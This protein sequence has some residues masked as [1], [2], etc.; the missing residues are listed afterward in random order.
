[1]KPLFAGLFDDAALFPPGD[2]PLAE[3]VPAHRGHRTAWY[4]GRSGTRPRVTV[5]WH[6]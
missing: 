1:M 3:A 4:A 5:A 2:L 6:R